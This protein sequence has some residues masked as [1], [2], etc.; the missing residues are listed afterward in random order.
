MLLVCNDVVRAVDQVAVVA[1]VLLDLSPALNTV[2]MVLLD[3]SPA[4]NTVAM[5]LLD[6]SPALNIVAMVLLDLSSALN[7]VAMVLLDL[8]SALNT[9]DHITLL[10]VLNSTFTVSRQAVAW[11]QSYICLAL[12]HQFQPVI[13]CCGQ[14]V[15]PYCPGVT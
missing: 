3:L 2:A 7:I 6:L 13:T 14:H 4:L 10:S 11:F 12:Y 8:S 9:V 5:V 1:M 15:S